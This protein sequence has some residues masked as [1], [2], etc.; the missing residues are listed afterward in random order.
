MAMRKVQ[1]AL[2][3]SEGRS[4]PW[5][6]ASLVNAFSELAEGEPPTV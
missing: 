1:P 6:G 4:K 3:T 2:Q 5:S